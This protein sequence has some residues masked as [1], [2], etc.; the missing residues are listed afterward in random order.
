M[1][2]SR[3]F[4]GSRPEPSG[5][6][7]GLEVSRMA[8]GF[9]RQNDWQKSDK[10]L[11][12]FIEQLIELGVTTMDHAYV[13]GSESQFGRILKDAPQLRD[14]MEIVSKWG[15]RPQGF[16]SLGAGSINHYDSSAEYLNRSLDQTLS[17]LNTDHLDLFLVH[18]PDY[19]MDVSELALA[20]EKIRAAG[21]ARFFGVSNFTRSQFELLQSAC[22]FPLATNQVE[23]S[24]LHL[25]PLDNGLFDQ[26]QML[27]LNPMLWSCLAGGSLFSAVDQRSRNV[28]DAF[29]AIASELETEAVDAVVYAWAM[30]LPC[31]P[32]PIIGSGNIE[33]VKTALNAEKISLNREQWYRVWEASMGHS[34]P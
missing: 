28:R 5:L 12:K 25:D 32:I 15:I 23:F 24:P 2:V 29:D 6:S 9:W 21:K 8:A 31:N 10:E 33:R 13:Y 17:D 26:C 16:G 1:S 34:V 20:L 4:I 18:R 27:S 14:K 7:S 19:L 22:D 30:M 3:I 11:Q